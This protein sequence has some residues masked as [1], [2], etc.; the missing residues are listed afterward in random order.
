M[1]RSAQQGFTLLELIVVMVL[2]GILATG[3]G[4]LI[5]R[6]I[7]A[8]QDQQ[9][10]QMLVDAAEM[11]LR[12]L[13][14]DIRHALPNSLRVVD[15]SPDGWV[16]ELV[17]AVDAGR[18]RDEN[19]GGHDT[20]DD[21]LEFT[22]A[23]DAFNL[24][25]GFTRLSAASPAAAYPAYRLVVYNTAPWQIYPQAASG[26]NPGVVSQPGFSLL[27]NASEPRLR[28][29][30]AHRFPLAS[31]AQRVYVV[32]QPVSYVCDAAAGTLTRYAG[33][34]FVASQAAIDSDAELAARPGVEVARMT[35]HV[36]ACGILYQPGSALRSGLVTLRLGLSDS[37]GG[38]V[39]LLH[40]V[41]AANAP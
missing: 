33:Y 27:S 37:R 4:L 35:R 2:L 9:R 39:S 23:D 1:R 18:Y 32:E 11:A 28:L 24:M 16:L 30:V 31:P 26:S 29:D 15:N 40:Q 34:G 41:H 17:P 5:N 3:A 22:A 38:R 20:A 36:D 14:T 7:E 12:K 6:P 25:G 19:G 21:R 8:Y 10:R 13:A